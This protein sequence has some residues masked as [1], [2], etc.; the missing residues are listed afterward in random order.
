MENVGCP[1]T[2]D[3]SSYNKM[4]TASELSLEFNFHCAAS[5]ATPTATFQ[6][7][8]TLTDADGVVTNVIQHSSTCTRT[9]LGS[10]AA[11]SNSEKPHAYIT[12]SSVDAASG[13]RKD[14]KPSWRFL[15]PAP[16]M[17]W[18]LLHK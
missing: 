18:F 16:T 12:E 5:P 11:S 4:H 9:G 1:D 14:A 3:C 13:P 10:R 6:W 8:T 17:P 2:W 15:R 7:K